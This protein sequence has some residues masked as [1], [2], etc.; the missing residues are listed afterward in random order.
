MKVNQIT[1]MGIVA[2][3][4]V[5]ITVIISP[6]SFGFLQFRVSSVLKCLF[7]KDKRYIIAITIGVILANVFSPYAGVWELTFM[8]LV[9]ILAAVVTCKLKNK[10]IIALAA[11]AIMTAAGVALMLKVIVGV[12]FWITLAS[13]T[14]SESAVM[15]IGQ[16]VL[17]RWVDAAIGKWGNNSNREIQKQAP[18]AT[19]NTANP[20]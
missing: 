17:L 12:P 10:P 8:P 13:V 16:K 4:Y 15:I 9:T 1:K 14:L 6:L 5:A 3:L 18:G 19:V 20:E 7:L 2:A 11:N